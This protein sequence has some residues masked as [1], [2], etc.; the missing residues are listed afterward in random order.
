M[1]QRP[2]LRDTDLKVTE[3]LQQE[4][5]EFLISAVD[6]I[7]QQYRW[8]GSD[9]GLEE[10]TWQQEVAREKRTLLTLQQRHSAIKRG[11]YGQE[12]AQLL[13]SI[14]TYSNCLLYSHSYRAFASSSPLNTKTDEL[15][16][17]G[18]RQHGQFR[19]A[20]A[21][22]PSAGSSRAGGPSRRPPSRSLYYTR[23][24]QP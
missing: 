4:R 22:G 13:L 8:L 21:R 6:F 16:L 1:A 18:L 23:S 17:G 14:C 24:L 12:C 9:N 20:H 19:F 10:R 3:Y 5:L 15:R 7:N 11:R 2:K